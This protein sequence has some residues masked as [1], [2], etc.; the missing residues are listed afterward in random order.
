[1]KQC[2]KW[3]LRLAPRT[4]VSPDNVLKIS[5]LIQA[6]CWITVFE[7][8]QEI[9]ISVGSVEEVL[10]SRLK[11]GKVGLMA[12]DTGA[13]GKMFSGHYLTFTAIWE[14]RS[15]IFGLSCELWWDLGPLL[16]TWLKKWK[17]IHPSP[18][19]KGRTIFSLG[20]IVATTFWDSMTSFTRTFSVVKRSSMRIIM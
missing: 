17:N 12:S 11:V 16:H 13:Q 14:R 7:L 2:R 18:P 8:S 3:T 6:N 20:K 10:H 4:S 5:E 15:W 19:R 9:G 1:M